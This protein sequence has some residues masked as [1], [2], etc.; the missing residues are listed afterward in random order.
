MF[1]LIGKK[2]GMSQVFDESGNLVPVTV[3]EI[4]PNKVVGERTVEKDGYSSVLLG[5]NPMK[6]N[7]LKKPYSGQF[8][9]GIEPYS[10]L[11]EFRDFG[12]DVKVGDTFGV[13]IFEDLHFVDVQGIS[14]GK[15]FQGVMKRHG[16][17]GGRKSHGSKFHRTAGS[18]GMAASPSKV[19]RGTRMAGRMGGDK[20]TIQ[21]LR[22][23]RIDRENE[24]LLVKGAIPGRKGG[25]VLVT[26]AR[27]HS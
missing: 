27:K 16:F 15:G 6:K 17:S 7:R 19:M 13:E 2:I 5:S 23:V 14:K 8:P 24:I 20:K 3:I 22:I 25:R 18:T 10:D 4:S 9:E 12:K 1:G 11:K 21:N 26:G